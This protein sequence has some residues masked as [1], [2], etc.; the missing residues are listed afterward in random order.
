[1]EKHFMLS[2]QF[3][4]FY[5]FLFVLLLFLWRNYIIE[6]TRKETYRLFI[7]YFCET[8]R[9]NPELHLDVH[10]FRTIK[11]I[12]NKT[13]PSQ[14]FNKA[15]NKTEKVMK[16]IEPTYDVIETFHKKISLEKDIR[17]G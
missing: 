5:I 2:E 14:S 11:Q 9:E 15:N 6:T 3:I 10:F 1:M 7:K 4:L 17:K 16:T 13:H 8:I 12:Y